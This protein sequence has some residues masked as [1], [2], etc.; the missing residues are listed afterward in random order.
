MYCTYSKLSSEMW[1]PI[2]IWY[3]CQLSAR[4][5][6]SWSAAGLVPHSPS[7]KPSL[8]TN[9]LYFSSNFSSKKLLFLPFL[10]QISWV[11]HRDIHLLTV[12]RYTYTSD[13]RFLSIHNPASDD[14]T[15]Q[16]RYPQRR[17]SGMYE[18]QVSTTPPIGHYMHLSVVGQCNFNFSRR[19]APKRVKSWM[20]TV[21]LFAKFLNRNS[22]FPPLYT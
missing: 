14:W 17:D 20:T 11:R 6:N 3:C 13:L 4:D 8:P 16:V 5:N 9:L 18:C 12:G 10:L 21:R 1:I 15:L 19:H 2:G 22:I 7:I